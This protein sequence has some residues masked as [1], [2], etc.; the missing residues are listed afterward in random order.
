M[1]AKTSA[2]EEKPLGSIVV[3]TLAVA[4]IGIKEGVNVGLLVGFDKVLSSLLNNEAAKVGK[5]TFLWR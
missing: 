4:G 5:K 2:S 3:D 1:S